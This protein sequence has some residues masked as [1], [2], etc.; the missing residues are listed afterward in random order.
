MIFIDPTQVAKLN[1]SHCSG[2][3]QVTRIAQLFSSNTSARERLEHKIKTAN[4]YGTHSTECRNGNGLG[5]QTEMVYNAEI[6]ARAQAP[7]EQR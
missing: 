2:N 1:H 4:G 7:I 5:T 3:P 6:N